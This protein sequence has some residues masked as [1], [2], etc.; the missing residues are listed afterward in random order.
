[1][2]KFITSNNVCSNSE[3]IHLNTHYKYFLISKMLSIL[4]LRILRKFRK[5]KN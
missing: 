3:F 1:M 4:I 5:E 2:S